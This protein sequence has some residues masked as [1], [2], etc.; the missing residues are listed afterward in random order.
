MSSLHHQRCLL[1]T[2]Q[3]SAGKLG[4]KAEDLEDPLP[5]IFERASKWKAILL[6]DEA[7]VFLERRAEHDLNRNALV[8]VFLRTRAFHTVV[9]Q[10]VVHQTAVL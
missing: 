5:L 1:L 7:D 9:C 6:L 4:T 3:V 8:C 10:I 2:S